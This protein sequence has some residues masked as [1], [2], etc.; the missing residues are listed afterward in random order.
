MHR[1]RD[2]NNIRIIGLY[3]L[4]DLTQI[5]LFKYITYELNLTNKRITHNADKMLQE[6]T[7]KERFN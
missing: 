2:Q 4:K 3:S 1:V 7:V 6:T 5:F